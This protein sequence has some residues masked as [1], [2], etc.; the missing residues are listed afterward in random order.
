MRITA[1]HGKKCVKCGVIIPRDAEAQWGEATGTVVHLGGC[2]Q[3][4]LPPPPQRTA[5]PF[6]T[7]PPVTQVETH[8]VT[9]EHSIQTGQGEHDYVRWSETI[10]LTGQA[11]E[12]DRNFL[13]NAV[14]KYLSNQLWRQLSRP[15][16]PA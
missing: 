1:P 15:V 11:T 6:P 8:M 16:A 9:F 10:K 3:Q 5:A 12:Q 13:S 4:A 14:E 2:P 7:P